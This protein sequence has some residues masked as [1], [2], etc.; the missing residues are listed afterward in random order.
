MREQILAN[1]NNDDPD[2]HLTENPPNTSL[3]QT[4][5]PC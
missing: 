5:A 2:E 1:G 4:T 3:T